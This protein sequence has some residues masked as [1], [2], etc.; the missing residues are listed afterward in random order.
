MPST[1]LRKVMRPRVFAM[2]LKSGVAGLKVAALP[3]IASVLG[4]YAG[5]MLLN[6]SY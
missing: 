3:K 6:C 1:T 5:F 2:I 4:I